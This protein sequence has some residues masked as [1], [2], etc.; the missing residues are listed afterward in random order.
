[1]SDFI[2]NM[3]EKMEWAAFRDAAIALDVGEGLPEEVRL[4]ARVAG[5]GTAKRR[6]DSRLSCNC[7]TMYTDIQTV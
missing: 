4:L 5:M 3:L 1:M 2:S 7:H 6:G